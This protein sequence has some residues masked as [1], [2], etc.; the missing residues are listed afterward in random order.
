MELVRVL[1]RHGGTFSTNTKNFIVKSI[2]FQQ[3]FLIRAVGH[4]L[5]PCNPLALHRVG[6]VSRF[7]REELGMLE[8]LLGHGV[9]FHVRDAQERHR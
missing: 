5:D 4:R 9:A 6:A 2:L 3:L 1:T 8:L 7:T